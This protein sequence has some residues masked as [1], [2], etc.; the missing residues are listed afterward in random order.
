MPLICKKP[1]GQEVG[2]L[3]FMSWDETGTAVKE[4]RF[5]Q[6]L[7]RCVLRRSHS[8]MHGFLKNQ[9]RSPDLLQVLCNKEFGEASLVY[10]GERRT[11]SFLAREGTLRPCNSCD[12]FQGL[13]QVLSRGL[14]LSTCVETQ[15]EIRFPS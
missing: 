6:M 13:P 12:K 4:C 10:K 9:S 5:C 1:S 8:A 7:P 3:V 14:A 15:W 2:D 11:H